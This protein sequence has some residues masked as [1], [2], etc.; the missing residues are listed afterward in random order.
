MKELVWNVR[1]AK[2]PSLNKKKCLCNK[3]LY[4]FCHSSLHNKLWVV[5]PMDQ[6]I[7]LY[8]SQGK[9]CETFCEFIRKK[10]ERRWLIKRNV[11]IVCLLETKVK[12]M[13]AQR[14]QNAIVLGWNFVHNYQFHQLGMIC[15]C[16]DLDLIQVKCIQQLEQ[17]LHLK[18][19]MWAGEFMSTFIY[20]LNDDKVV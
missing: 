19:L 2:W 3:K 17:L 5:D 10:G 15:L 1:G 7:F 4:N 12:E 11:S 8:H 13:N 9:N 14:I 6:L 18:I 20:A 16:W